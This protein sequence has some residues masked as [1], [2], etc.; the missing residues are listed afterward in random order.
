MPGRSRTIRMGFKSLRINVYA[1]A[2][3]AEIL[4]AAERSVAVKRLQRKARAAG[5]AKKE[6]HELTNLFLIREFV[7]V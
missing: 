1:L 6:S 5:N 3:A 7:A 4:F 2:I